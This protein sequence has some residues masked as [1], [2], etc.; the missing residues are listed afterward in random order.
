MSTLHAHSAGG[1]IAANNMA[2]VEKEILLQGDLF[3]LLVLK[4]RHRLFELQ[5]RT[6]LDD[7]G[8]LPLEHSPVVSLMTRLR[9]LTS[10]NS[11]LSVCMESSVVLKV[12][13]SSDSSET[14]APKS[15]SLS[16]LGEEEL[17]TVPAGDLI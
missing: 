13:L 16:L 17:S 12:T 3:L 1:K 6:P 5:T 14:S 10:S 9:P 2:D 4:R 8:L 15:S 7:F 11:R